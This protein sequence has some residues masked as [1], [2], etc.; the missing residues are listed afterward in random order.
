MDITAVLIDDDSCFREK[1]NNHLRLSFAE[2]TTHEFSHL[3]EVAI[4]HP[5]RD[6]QGM[7]KAP[8]TLVFVSESCIDGEISD[9][10]KRYGRQAT[11]I[12]VTKTTPQQI[13]SLHSQAG[14]YGS[15]RYK[16]YFMQRD[17][18]RS[19]LFKRFVEDLIEDT[20]HLQ[21]H[22]TEETL[23][24]I[25]EH[26]GNLH[27]EIN[28]P[29]EVLFATAY[30]LGHSEVIRDEQRRAAQRIEE[31]GRRIKLVL[32]SICAALETRTQPFPCFSPESNVS[33]GQ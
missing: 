4:N 5:I 18:I 21:H 14:D 29:L 33:R 31:S 12:V 26:M 7:S 30:L 16:I 1:L 17:Q 9:F 10:L 3:E 8:P 27:H 20:I 13:S 24:R 19:P 25:Q 15:S 23:H 11:L 6:D 22:E 32:D 28:N 2:V